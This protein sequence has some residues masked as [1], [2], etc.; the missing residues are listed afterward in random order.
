MKNA[1]IT[2]TEVQ[3]IDAKTLLSLFKRVELQLQELTK[4]VNAKP[5]IELMAQ[6]QVAEML[7]VSE[8]TI[9]NWKKKG[10]LTAYRIGNQ[11]RFKR[12]E[13]LEAMQS[14]KFAF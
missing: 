14:S 12:H 2:K 7:G 6:K 10:I 4:T 5:Q 3:G 13:V 11:I 9:Y 1:N 8:T